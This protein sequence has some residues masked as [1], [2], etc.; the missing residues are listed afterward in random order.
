MSAIEKLCDMMRNFSGVAD[1][2]FIYIEEAQGSDELR[3]VDGIYFSTPQHKT[4][5]Q[6]FDAATR[7]LD[8]WRIPCPVYVDKMDNMAGALYAAFPERLYVINNGII[9]YTG[10]CGLR[11]GP[12]GYRPSEVKEWLDRYAGGCGLRHGPAGY[13]PSEVKE[14]LDRYSGRR[15]MK[16]KEENGSISVSETCDS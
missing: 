4:L 1:F 15:I 5:E 8:R 6:R 2:I 16:A 14:W 13:R 12:A 9:E 10:G 7:L 3:F 11:H